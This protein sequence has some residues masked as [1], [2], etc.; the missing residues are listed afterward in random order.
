MLELAHG[1]ATADGEALGGIIN[2]DPRLIFTKGDIEGL[3]HTALDRLVS[4]DG[5]LQFLLYRA[6]VAR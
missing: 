2:P 3:V 5:P 6:R 4:P 1:D